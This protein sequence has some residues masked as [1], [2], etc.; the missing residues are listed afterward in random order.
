MLWNTSSIG[1]GN[2][3][4][5]GKKK[6]PVELDKDQLSEF[7]YL[8][9]EAEGFKTE[10]PFCSSNYKQMKGLLMQRVSPSRYV[11]SLSVA[12]TARKLARA[13]G[14]DEDQ[15]RMA[16][17]LHDWDK[18]LSPKRLACRVQD[19]SLPIAPETVQ[20]MPWVLH[21]STAA[22]VLGQQFPFLGS[23]VLQAID[24]HTVGSPDMAP[25][26]MIVF[27]AD[28]IEPTHD[29]PEYKRLYKQI[30]VMGLEDM[31]CAVLKEGMAHLVKTNRPISY[32]TVLVWN[33]YCN[34]CPKG[35]GE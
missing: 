21:G 28:K 16:G 1:K 15:A 24:R 27:V 18:A 25:L 4:A 23:E 31:F 32:D 7:A 9:T 26:D 19:F 2:P 29:V 22:A 34:S 14:V 3:M 10:K 30:G 17:L 6:Q 13:Y 35:K 12:K 11:H 5:K 20:D 8:P 33:R